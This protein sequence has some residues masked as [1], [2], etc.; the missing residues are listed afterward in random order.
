MNPFE[1][2]QRNTDFAL[3]LGGWIDV[4]AEASAAA[5]SFYERITV[6]GNTTLSVEISTD[7][8]L[9]WIPFASYGAA[10]ND[11][12][13]SPRELSLLD[14]VGES[15][16][17]RFRAQQ[18]GAWFVD[19]WSIDDVSVFPMLYLPHSQIVTQQILVAQ[20]APTASHSPKPERGYAVYSRSIFALLTNLYHGRIIEHSCQSRNMNRI[21][22]T[23]S[24]RQTEKPY[25]LPSLPSVCSE[26]LW[27]DYL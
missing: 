19:H 27:V 18:G 26:A 14:F 22:I 9:N 17:I 11:D 20:R 1:G 10:K 6:A 21:S 16:R 2:N 15:I 4:P 7:D 8:G 24:Q 12:A 25:S 13:W 5:L 23:T 3:T